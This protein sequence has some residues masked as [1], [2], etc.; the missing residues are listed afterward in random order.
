MYSR[1]RQTRI[2]YV[3]YK[4][5]LLH[6]VEM[7]ACRKKAKEMQNELASLCLLRLVADGI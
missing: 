7:N 1:L 6:N 3:S 4:L 5:K 2:A